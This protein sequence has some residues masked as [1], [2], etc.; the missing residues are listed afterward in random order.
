MAQNQ[1]II[2]KAIGE[3]EDS[4]L[5]A[6]Y[7]FQDGKKLKEYF[8]TKKEKDF[9][10]RMVRIK[11]KI[12]KARK[13]I[14]FYRAFG[15]DDFRTLSAE[16]IQIL[17]FDE[18]GKPKHPIGFDKVFLNIVEKCGVSQEELEIAFAREIKDIIENNNGARHYYPGPFYMQNILNW[19]FYN[20]KSATEY[21]CRPIYPTG[22]S[23]KLKDPI[24]GK[25]P[26]FN[27]CMYSEKNL[28][29]AI[30]LGEWQ[31]ISGDR[32]L[33]TSRIKL[34]ELVLNSY[35]GKAA[36]DL[37]GQPIFGEDRK[38]KKIEKK[39][40]ETYIMITPEA[41]ST[42]KIQAKFGAQLKAA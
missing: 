2:A 27:G 24:F 39:G 23:T 1:E 11:D 3:C 15:L 20:E 31:Y 14:R 26:A 8:E 4:D 10:R 37:F 40:N 38:I 29:T 16:E 17:D 32:P 9:K 5:V 30:L 22:K 36:D 42:S 19:G 7:L 18:Y 6:E 25:L 12:K 33:L 13:A 35:E 34:P 41:S 28:K 21:R